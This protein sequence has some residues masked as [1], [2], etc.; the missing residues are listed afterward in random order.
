MVTLEGA[1]GN[2][3]RRHEVVEFDIGLVA[4]QVA[5]LAAVVPPPRFVDQHR[6]RT[7]IGRPHTGELD[8][9]VRQDGAMSDDAQLRIAW[10]H[11]VGTTARAD[12][13]LDAVIGA[14]RHPTRRYHGVRHVTWVVRHVQELAEGE[15]TTD[16]GSLVAAAFY[17]DAIYDARATDN[18]ERS[19]RWA[20][21]ALPAL[22]WST[23]RSGVVGDLV[24]LTAT[25][26]PRPRSD[27]ALLVDADLAVLGADPAGYHAYATGVRV[28][29]AHVPDQAWRTGRAAVLRGFLERPTIFH[30]ATGRSR[31][32][33]RARANLAAE[34]AT[35]TPPAE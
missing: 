11:H 19:A 13:E 6:H 16:L 15:P 8:V 10:R 14:H 33:S 17:H 22:G 34:L 5:P 30:T 1:P 28:E 32:E 25:H 20:E 29:Y 21:R 27:G 18:E 9:G 31:W 7:H 35:L 26:Q 4:D 12:A 23:A 3:E 24:R 2:P